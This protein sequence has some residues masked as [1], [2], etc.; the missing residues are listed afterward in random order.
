MN[1]NVRFA[2]IQGRFSDVLDTVDMAKY[3]VTRSQTPSLNGCEFN[4][5]M[6]H[7]LQIDGSI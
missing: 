6:P 1:E 5:E 2:R 4:I 3:D 7:S